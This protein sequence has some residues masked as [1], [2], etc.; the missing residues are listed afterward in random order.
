VA[1][2]IRCRSGLSEAHDVLPVQGVWSV[3]L[4]DRSYEAG[5]VGVLAEPHGLGGQGC[6]SAR[7]TSGS[8][9]AN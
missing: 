4:C 3:A 6:L 2:S 9:L 1:L 8:M 5:V 7:F